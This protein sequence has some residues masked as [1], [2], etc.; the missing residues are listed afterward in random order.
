M[1]EKLKEKTRE[2]LTSVLPITVI[3]LMLSV[4]LVPMEVGT[5]ALF[6]TGAVLLI[7]VAMWLAYQFNLHALNFLFSWVPRSP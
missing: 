5:L 7:V 3:V 4:T 6:L 2:A 1:N